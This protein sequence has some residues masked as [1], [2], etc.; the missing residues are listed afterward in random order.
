MQET[1][2]NYCVACNLPAA[3]AIAL[4]GLQYW[5]FVGRIWVAPSGWQTARLTEVLTSV[6]GHVVQ[7]KLTSKLLAAITR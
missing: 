2:Q 5:L 3:G 6:A 7:T 4:A 1:R